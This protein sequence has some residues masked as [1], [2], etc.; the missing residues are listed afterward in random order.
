MKKRDRWLMTAALTVGVLT[1]AAGCGRQEETKPASASQ[2]AVEEAEDDTSETSGTLSQEEEG[3][4]QGT[5]TVSVMTGTVL[6]AAM[7][8]IVIQNQEYP[9]GII[10]SK[11]DSAASFTDGLTL[12]HD[13]T[14]FYTGRIQGDDTTETEVVLVRDGRD[15]DDGLAAFLVSGTVSAVSGEELTVEADDKTEVTVKRGSELM[16]LEG[17]PQE[18]DLVTVLYSC[19]ESGTEQKQAELIR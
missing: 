19:P 2:S 10:F 12:G 18:G 15:G 14:L 8:S 1:F 11:E 5:E 3:K 17:E 9:D 13:A 4:T 6:D 16:E 7:N